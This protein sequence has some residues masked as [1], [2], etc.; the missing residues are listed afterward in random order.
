[1]NSDRSFRRRLPALLIAVGVGVNGSAHGQVTRDVILATTTSTHDSGL[2]DSLVPRFEARCK[3]RVK[4]V[5]VGTGQALA[6]GARG[7]ADVVLVHAPAL[8]KKYVREGTFINRRLVMVNDF[9]LVGPPGD[10]AKLKGS[11][12]LSE[13]MGKLGSGKAPFASRADSSGTDILERN[14]WKSAGITPAGDW[15]IEVGQGMG[16]TLRIASEKEAYTLTDRGTYLALRPTLEL[17][18]VFEGAPEL[19]NVYHVMEPNPD[20]FSN[21]NPRGGRAFA[22]FMVSPSTQALIGRFGVGRFG[23]A[24]FRPAAGTREPAEFPAAN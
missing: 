22:D 10:P 20:I 18:T 1:M 24:L 11:A 21:T 4:T 6:L 12:T 5:A 3:C 14:L 19:L 15:Y 16:A 23:Q 13:A 17:E 8:E 2:L 7:E 9:I